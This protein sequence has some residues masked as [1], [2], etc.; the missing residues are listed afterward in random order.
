[1]QPP[2]ETPDIATFLVLQ[3]DLMTSA[4]VRLGKSSEASTWSSRADAFATRLV[5]A[6]W[7]GPIWPAP[8][9]LLIDALVKCR[10]SE[11][12]SLLLQRFCDLVSTAGM[13]ENFDAQ[14][15]QGY[16]DFHFSWTASIF[17]IL[18]NELIQSQQDTIGY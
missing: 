14:T 10:E 15:G 2:V 16:H 12:A 11:F 9:L 4:A 18:A 5:E 13:A 7:R 6:F 1:M 3:M 17:L 8:T